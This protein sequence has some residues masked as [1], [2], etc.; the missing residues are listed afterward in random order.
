MADNSITKTPYDFGTAIFKPFKSGP[1]SL[2]FVFKSGIFYA[3]AI[4]MLLAIFG[5]WVIGPYIEVIA[6]AIE[7]ETSE[8]PT[9]DEME[10]MSQM[11]SA[12][13]RMMA[14]YMIIMIGGWAVWAM[15]ESALHRRVLRKEYKGGLFPWRFHHDEL[16][17]MLSQLITYFA[18]NGLFMV[19]YFVGII[20]AVIAALLGS[21]SVVLGV[22]VGIIAAAV[23]IVGFGIMIYV[24]IRLAP[25]A[26]RN[27][28]ENELVIDKAWAVGK[29]RSWPSFGAYAFHYIVSSIVFYIIAAVLFFAMIGSLMPIFEKFNENM[30]ADEVMQILSEA[31]SEPGM[32][33]GLTIATF[34]MCFM[35]AIW[36]MCIAGISSHVTELY[37]NEQEEAG[38]KVFD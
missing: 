5:R 22:I 3:L 28:A 8:N 6:I 30:E 26:A 25:M 18:Y 29:G 31:F 16:R 23:I 9:M 35:A 24:L 10:M 20:V 21:K 34:I 19:V 36:M 33:V 7:Q 15:I 11:M 37:M 12:M 32:M 13:G 2:G 14:G 38:A 17:T 1:G 27:V 4:T